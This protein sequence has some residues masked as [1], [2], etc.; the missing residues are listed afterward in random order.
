M[1]TEDELQK[2]FFSLSKLETLRERVLND[3]LN[4][5]KR[6]QVKEII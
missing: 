3:A 4:I 1:L 2:C 6:S 5:D